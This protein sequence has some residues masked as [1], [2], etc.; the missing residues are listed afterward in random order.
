MAELTSEQR[1]VS[2]IIDSFSEP[3][4]TPHA[5][6]RL[7]Q[8]LKER[9]GV[10]KYMT[11]P[12]IRG[13]VGDTLDVKIG[14][15]ALNEF[16]PP[17]VQFK[18]YR[19]VEREQGESTQGYASTHWH[20]Y[21]PA[22]KDIGLAVECEPNA[23]F[24]LDIRSMPTAGLVLAHEMGH[25]WD[26]HDNPQDRAIFVRNTLPVQILHDVKDEQIRQ[27]YQ[28]A[29][30][31]ATKRGRLD[32]DLLK[33]LVETD[34]RG[35]ARRTALEARLKGSHISRLVSPSQFDEITEE[36]GKAV[37]EQVLVRGAPLDQQD[38]AGSVERVRQTSGYLQ[39]QFLRKRELDS[40]VRAWLKAEA[41]TK[42]LKKRDPKISLWDGDEK[43]L[44]LL[45]AFMILHH[46]EVK[47]EDIPDGE[48]K[49]LLRGI[50]S[51]AKIYR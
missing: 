25:A 12:D 14:R 50:T 28:Q 7:S 44:R 23:S 19:H 18:G 2:Q 24:K 29:R 16:L 21:D 8:G 36:I 41:I 11:R 10:G 42:S 22:T 33:R 39:K 37:A 45:K 1:K 13:G 40:E 15:V 4:R 32:S 51:I 47:F 5:L 3:P 49:E 9:F 20:F 17:G 35:Q 26:D 34:I 43:S 31:D 46:A 6:A 30:S 38:L 48:I 27:W